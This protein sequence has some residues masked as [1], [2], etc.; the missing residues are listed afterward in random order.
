MFRQKG[1]YPAKERRCEFVTSYGTTT[2]QINGYSHWSY[3]ASLMAGDLMFVAFGNTGDF[4]CAAPAGFKKIHTTEIYSGY[5][6]ALYYRHILPSHPG[7][8]MG[9][10]QGAA[11]FSYAVYR[12][13]F[14]V[15]AVTENIVYTYGGTGNPAPA[16]CDLT[17]SGKVRA[18]V[19]Q[20][21]SNYGSTVNVSGVAP[22]FIQNVNWNPTE[23]Y[24]AMK[25]YM[26]WEAGGSTTFDQTDTTGARSHHTSTIELDVF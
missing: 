12:P 6:V 2:S 13:N 26:D 9:V 20:V 5:W 10:W 3:P 11:F 19:C 14:T 24:F 4:A 15:D 8:N 21:T 7:T 25:L 23:G 16:T 17:A 18:A 1:L 22:D